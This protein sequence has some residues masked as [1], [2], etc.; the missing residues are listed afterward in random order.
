M[1]R[2]P[3]SPGPAEGACHEIG[4]STTF[5][6]A[7]LSIHL[8]SGNQQVIYLRFCFYQLRYG[9]DRAVKRSRWVRFVADALQKR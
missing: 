6:L 9:W 3:S 4:P 7:P 8:I 5:N 2:F 1:P